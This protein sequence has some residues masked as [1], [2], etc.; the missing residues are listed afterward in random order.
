LRTYADTSFLVK[1][2][3]RESGS[4]AAVA[5]YRRFRLPR[6]FY[7]PLHAL[8]VENAARQKAFHQRR[9]LPSGERAHVAR[10]KTAV[11]SR[12]KSML[13]HNQFIEVAADWEKAVSRA[14]EL[15]Q[16]HT[17]SLGA[18]S[19]DLLHIAFALELQCELF[20]TA[21]LCQGQVA[22]AEGLKVVTVSDAN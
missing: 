21:D 2:I 7:L 8:E 18:R 10:E 14:R 19:L 6:L 15:S 22:R 4:E 17:E 3:A 11:L 13:E 5:E 9:T 20:F 1:L 16:K 12:L